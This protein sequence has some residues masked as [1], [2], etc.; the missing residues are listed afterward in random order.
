MSSI[1]SLRR[2][3][4][5]IAVAP[6]LFSLYDCT[7]TSPPQA[8]SAGGNIGRFDLALLMRIH[9]MRKRLACEADLERMGALYR[10]APA[11]QVETDFLR[12]L[13]EIRERALRDIERATK[14]VLERRGLDLAVADRPCDPW[15]W[16][17]MCWQDP[18]V[19]PKGLRTSRSKSRGF[20]RSGELSGW[21]TC[22]RTPEV[23]MSVRERHGCK[24]LG[25]PCSKEAEPGAERGSRS[26]AAPAEAA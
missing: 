12:Q 11:D 6:I 25:S 26:I 10:G 19:I 24:G 7:A 16:A 4:L 23:K 1:A 20:S 18:G 21:T 17:G 14:V 2:A 9:P 5:T 15:Y 3:I 22:L 8:R 13:T